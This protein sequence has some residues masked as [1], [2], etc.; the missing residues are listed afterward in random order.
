M[1]KMTHIYIFTYSLPHIAT[2]LQVECARETSVAIAKVYGAALTLSSMQFVSNIWLHTHSHVRRHGITFRNMHSPMVC[3]RES[4]GGDG[5]LQV[6]EPQPGHKFLCTLCMTDARLDGRKCVCSAHRLG[7]HANV[8][9]TRL[10]KPTRSARP[11]PPA[12]RQPPKTQ[13]LC[14]ESVRS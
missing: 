13:P 10:E 9:V 11:V 3:R 4:A 12:T 6:V 14:R 2:Y 8:F 1:G 7:S 5:L